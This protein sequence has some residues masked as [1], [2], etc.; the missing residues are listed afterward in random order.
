MGLYDAFMNSLKF[1][2]WSFRYEIG[3]AIYT[4]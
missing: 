4:A 3:S 2:L 1:R